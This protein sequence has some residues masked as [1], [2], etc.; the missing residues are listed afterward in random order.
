MILN[1]SPAVWVSTVVISRLVFI[2]A[3]L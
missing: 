2:F 1:G 3:L